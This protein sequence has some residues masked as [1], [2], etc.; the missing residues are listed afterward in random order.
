MSTQTA[1]LRY[2]VQIWDQ[3]TLQYNGYIARVEQLDRVRAG[4]A[5]E[6]CR[7]DRQVHAEALKVDDYGEYEHGG[8]QVG[9][10]GQVLAVEGFLE[11]A[12]F[13]VAS[14]Q[15]VEESNDGALELCATAGVDCRRTERFPHDCLAD[16]GRYEERYAWAETVAL[17]EQF[18]EQQHD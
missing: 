11:S 14:G 10:I 7:L 8:Q 18:V 3:R 13:V 17:L 16:V 9:Q 6:S 4:L 12:H 1:Y 15:Q 2:D 5:A